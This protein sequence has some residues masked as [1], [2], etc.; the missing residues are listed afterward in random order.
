MKKHRDRTTNKGEAYLKKYPRLQ[1]WIKQ[2]VNC[3]ERGYDP[4]MPDLVGPGV[5]TSLKRWFS[6]LSL[7]EH[8]VCN[9]CESN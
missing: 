2:C 4:A 8:G 1:K 5:G 9:K 7:N 6:P 3:Q